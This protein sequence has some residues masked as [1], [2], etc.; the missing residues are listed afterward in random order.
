MG[1]RLERSSTTA[2][3]VAAW[4]RARPEVAQ[5]L[6]PML[7]GAPGHALWRRDFTGGCGLFTVVLKGKDAAARDA[8]IDAL[9]LFGIGYSWGGF[10]SLALGVHPERDRT[11]LPW[12]PAGSDP[13]DRFAIRFWIGLE[14]TADLKADLERGLAAWVAA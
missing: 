13:A 8:L 12:P 3:E 6:F 1:V 5:V 2:L 7:S 4:L 11:A 14:E 10:E 9:A